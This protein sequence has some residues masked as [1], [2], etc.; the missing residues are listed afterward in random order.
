MQGRRAESGME[1]SCAWDARRRQRCT[2]DAE[3]PN[4]INFYDVTANVC[5]SSGE[6]LLGVPNR[7]LSPSILYLE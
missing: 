3:I 1:E 7:P 6:S 5:L 2:I 4:A